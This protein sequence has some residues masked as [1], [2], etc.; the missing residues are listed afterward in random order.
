VPKLRQ[1]KSADCT[2]SHNVFAAKIWQICGSYRTKVAILGKEK[3]KASS[4]AF[5]FLNH[6]LIA[7]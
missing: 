1:Q 7:D 2:G 5:P 3:G 6:W 4:E